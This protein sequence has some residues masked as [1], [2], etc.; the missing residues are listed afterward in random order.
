MVITMYY[1]SRSACMLLYNLVRYPLE[2]FTKFD[3]MEMCDSVSN[4]LISIGCSMYFDVVVHPV[5]KNDGMV[6]RAFIAVRMKDPEIIIGIVDRII[7]REMTLTMYF[8]DK[9][10]DEYALNS[11]SFRTV[12]TEGISLDS[13]D[14]GRYGFN[15]IE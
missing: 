4:M 15:G 14:G 11:V 1:L 10:G 9:F 3:P 5:V 8:T 7:L 12:G 13:M 2:C 6:Y